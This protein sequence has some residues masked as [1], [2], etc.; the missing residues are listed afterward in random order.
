MPQPTSTDRAS[1]AEAALAA[2]QARTQPEG[3]AG[4]DT[5]LEHAMQLRN[6]LVDLMHYADAK[7][8]DFGTL[9]RSA[10]RTYRLQAE[11]DSPD[12]SGGVTPPARAGQGVIDVL[13]GDLAK[14]M[15]DLGRSI[16]PGESTLGL[17]DPQVASRLLE[18]LR[19]AMRH[20]RHVLPQVSDYLQRELSAGRLEDL[21]DDPEQAVHLATLYLQVA[22]GAATSLAG[23]LGRTQQMLAHLKAP[24]R[25]ITIGTQLNPVQLAQQSFPTA[26]PDLSTSTGSR[27]SADSSPGTPPVTKNVPRP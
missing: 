12:H 11:Q 24:Q 8:T 5:D 20:L 19:Q 22:Q 13:A 10:S 1:N 14:A 16:T 4:G 7:V 27:R 18:G 21:Q 23:A 9:L 6:L 26:T 2:Y 3:D 17:S 25:T 15:E